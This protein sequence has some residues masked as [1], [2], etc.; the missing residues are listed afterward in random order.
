MSCLAMPPLCLYACSINPL[1]YY[2][3]KFKY[4]VYLSLSHMEQ[5]LLTTPK[6][7]FVCIFFILSFF[8]C[9]LPQRL[10][11]EDFLNLNCLIF[12]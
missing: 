8:S 10:V 5:L 1:Q 11:W 2:C 6:D 7:C 9:L 3:N 12:V 4:L